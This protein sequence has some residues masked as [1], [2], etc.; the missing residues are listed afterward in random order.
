MK[1]LRPPETKSE[2]LLAALLDGS[3][4]VSRGRSLYGLSYC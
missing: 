4:V 3:L 1:E 2:P